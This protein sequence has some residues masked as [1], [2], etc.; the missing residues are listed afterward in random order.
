MNTKSVS[1]DS[2]EFLKETARPSGLD[3]IARRAV[4]SRLASLEAGQ[5]VITENGRHHSFGK[6]TD[7]FPL[8]AQIRVLHP[9]FY[10][11]VAFGGSIGAGEAYIHH[12]WECDELSNLLRILLRNRRVLERMDS[13]LSVLGRPP[14]ALRI[15][16][17]R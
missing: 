8:T 2:P 5:I 15:R 3:K 4:L 1:I 14:F 9:R 16:I 6:L 12:Y 17:A 13:G 10:S 11:D 7:E